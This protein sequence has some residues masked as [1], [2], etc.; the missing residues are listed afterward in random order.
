M[1]NIMYSVTI[2][3]LLQ[4]IG[5]GVLVGFILGLIAFTSQSSFVMVITILLSVIILLLAAMFAELYHIR[6]AI[7]KQREE[8]KEN[9]HL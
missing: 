3:K 1:K 5:I 7:N 9:P 6:E 2:Q 8:E 4:L